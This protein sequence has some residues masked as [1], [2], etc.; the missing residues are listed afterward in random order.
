M[1]FTVYIPLVTE[2]DKVLRTVRMIKGKNILFAVSSLGLGH[3]TREMPVIKYFSGNNKI[4]IISYGE[5]L[6]LLR[7]E[8]EGS[9]C[10]FHEYEDYPLSKRGKGLMSI[11]NGIR[12]LIRTFS[13]MRHE[14]IL[15]EELTDKYK[16]DFI[17]SDCRYGCYSKRIP[18][19]VVSHQIRFAF[20]KAFKFISP[21]TDA[22]NYKHFRHFTKVLIP[23]YAEEHKNL[24]GELSHNKLAEKLRAEYVGILSSLPK[25]KLEKEIDYLFFISGFLIEHFNLF[26]LRFMEEAGKLPGRK[27]FVMG[28]LT[29][30]EH[31]FENNNIE[32][33]SHAIG[34]LRN[35]LLNR[36]KAVISRCGYTTVMD[37]A[38]IDGVG[39]FIPTPTQA[40]QGYLAGYFMK[41]NSFVAFR[42]QK[43]FTLEDIEKRIRST[44]FFRTERKTKDSLMKI[45]SIISVCLRE[46]DQGQ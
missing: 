20:S 18:S 19:F 45:E 16:V 32:I 42:S 31:Y 40:E 33:Y 9:G 36:S 12:G 4:F 2:N 15:T 17:M 22:F 5:A 10:T 39:I 3:A 23:D 29:N 44:K 27:V 13:I 28:D 37:L 35:E 24:A 46:K 38:E 8:F 14:H 21:V 26:L 11:V 1:L 7:L 34:D 43:E 6:K 25:L 30:N 41:E